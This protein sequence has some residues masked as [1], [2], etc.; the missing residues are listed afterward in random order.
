MSVLTHEPLISDLKQKNKQTNFTILFS[1]YINSCIVLIFYKFK[2][3]NLYL[4]KKL[5]Q[6]SC[7]SNSGLM[8]SISIIRSLCEVMV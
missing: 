8:G 6:H 7:H 4:L 5:F 1:V 3:L 2:I